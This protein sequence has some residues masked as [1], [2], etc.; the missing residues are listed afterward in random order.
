VLLA[1]LAGAGWV[2]ASMFRLDPVTVDWD[3]PEAPELTAGP[4]QTLYR[5]D[6]SRSTATYEVEEILAG[7]GSTA[8]GETQGI[9]GDILVDEDDPAASEVGEI[10]INVE[11]LTSDESLR[12]E[13]LRQDYLESDQHPLVTFATRDV[14]GIP[15]AIE[16]G[17][18]YEV[19]LLGDLTIKETTREVEVT[20]TVTRDDGELHVVAD[21]HILLSD[22]DAGPI[23]IT[24][25]VRSGDDA[26][27][28]L[29]LVAPEADQLRIDEQESD[30]VEYEV[31]TADDPQFSATVQP[32]LESSCASC[33][34]PGGAGSGTWELATAGDAARVASGIG[35]AVESRYMPPWLASEEGVAL[36]HSPRLT[37]EELA[38]ITEWADAG[39]PLDV[40]PETR[41]E[42]TETDGP[43][44]RTD[45]EL[46][47]PEPYTGTVEKENDYR[48]FTLDPGLTE[49]AAVTGYQFLPDQL[50]I[51]HH[52][53]VYRVRADSDEALAEAEARDEDPGWECFGGINV[54]GSG[55]S[56][57]GMGGSD[58]LMGWA[59]GQPPSLFPE[60]TGMK[61][62]PGDKLVVQMHY[63]VDEAP[64]PDQS[65]IA[66]QMSD[67][68]PGE[69]DDIEVSTY[70]A[71]A[72]I[73]CLPEDQDAPRCDR[74]VEMEA[75]REQY[76]PAGP[77]IANGL[78]LVCGTTPEE[79]SHLDED[80]IARTSCDHGVSSTGE[81]LAV[82]GHMHEI[83]S[84]FRMTLN[85][86]TP[87]E[88]V[89]LDI[90]RWDFDWQFNY[91]L[92]EDIT[93]EEGDV[94]RVEC[95]WD[96][97]LV[98]PTDEP[99]H[100][101][102]AEGTEDEMCYSTLATRSSG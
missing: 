86:D 88:Q 34:E 19:T 51:V 75:L 24:G 64:P 65:S 1:C 81:V 32:V 2:G 73:P 98:D 97:A 93:L 15:D 59:P 76:G 20:G 31:A 63:H 5:I 7:V 77:T 46:T 60:G 94:I 53:L 66:L 23:S 6:P 21:A 101:S 71:P 44:L 54:S 74:A 3:V 27:L 10:V 72:E 89:L 85:P 42:A 41:V 18:A 80:G 49:P 61:L 13:R 52:A 79:I 58:L 57:S 12:D 40:D 84:T 99:H 8:T 91:A 35:L 67:V 14:Q 87:E 33:H 100:I 95:S 69:L 36:Q 16:D 45:V 43:E 22:F 62:A 92:D 102:W 55:L 28:H 83:G 9:A 37:D 17:T 90:P 48:C 39:G 47:L 82:L 68:D 25:L 4:G 70:L 29:D 26:D 56:A 11:Q 30:Q 96:R 78:H 50:P 38:A